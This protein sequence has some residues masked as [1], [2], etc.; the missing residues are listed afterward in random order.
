MEEYNQG[1]RITGSSTR[2]IRALELQIASQQVGNGY[3]VDDDLYMETSKDS[4]NTIIGTYI[5]IQ[6]L[7][8]IRKST[9]NNSASL[10]QRSQHCE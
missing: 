7:Y 2:N 6:R 3:F 8:I 10:K 5:M 9:G 1:R 4:I